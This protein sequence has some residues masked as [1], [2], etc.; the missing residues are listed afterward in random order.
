MH[1]LQYCVKVMQ[2]I[3]NKYRDISAM[4][5]KIYRFIYQRD[6]VQVYRHGIVKYTYT[7]PKII[8]NNEESSSLQSQLFE[9]ASGELNLLMLAD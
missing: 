9:V 5:N 3:I 2:T 4:F 1:K 8:Y 6:I 7:S